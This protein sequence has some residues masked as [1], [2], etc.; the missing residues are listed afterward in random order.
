VNGFID[1]GKTGLVADNSQ[2]FL[3][4]ADYFDETMFAMLTSSNYRR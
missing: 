3:L 2:M 4:A 1:A